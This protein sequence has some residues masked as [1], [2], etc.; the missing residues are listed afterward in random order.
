MTQPAVTGHIHC[1][2][3]GC[4]WSTPFVS[5][6]GHSWRP[7]WTAV[8]I[9]RGAPPLQRLTDHLLTSHPRRGH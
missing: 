6:L 4:E 9:V 5:H 7:G 1:P 3:A 2:H 8:P